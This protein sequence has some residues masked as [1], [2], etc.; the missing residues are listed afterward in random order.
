MNDSEHIYI[1]YVDDILVLT[2]VDK[3]NEAE[4]ILKTKISELKLVL[5][6]T[7]TGIKTCE[8]GFDYL[9]YHFELP[10]VTVKQ[11]T[12][13][14]FIL[15][16]SAKFSSYIHSKNKKLK[17]YNYLTEEK[18]KEMFVSDLNEKITGAISE[19]RRYGWIFYFGAMNDISVLYK[20]D[21]IIRN[22]FSRLE[23]F[24]RVAP[25]ELK[26]L[27]RAFYEAK[28]NPKNGYIH[29]YNIYETTIQK[30]NFLASR[31]KLDP[32][33]EYS[34]AE[35]NEIFERVKRKNLVELEQ[36]NAHQY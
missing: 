30:I 18:L 12:I 6:Q 22:L 1:R 33:K 36:D 24:N 16:I 4:T 35:I 26:K 8:E 7:K 13:E 3:I 31:G 34:E 14:N 23:D 20:I 25:T 5:H 11:N 19:N 17:K 28:Y 32:R 15:S 2:D 21:N 10:K 29:N 9:G 27:S